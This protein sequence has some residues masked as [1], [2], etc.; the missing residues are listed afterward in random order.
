MESTAEERSTYHDTGSEDPN[1]IAPTLQTINTE[2]ILSWLEKND[3]EAF[4]K[5]QAHINEFGFN[6]QSSSG[7]NTKISPVNGSI[8]SGS[9][10]RFGGA[11]MNHINILGPPADLSGPPADN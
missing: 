11:P 5:F 1:V 8:N 9:T 10:I 7:K 2:M 3:P 4:T 6:V